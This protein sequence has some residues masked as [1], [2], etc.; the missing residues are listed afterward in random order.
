M[1]KIKIN[2]IKKNN[3]VTKKYIYKF[4][5]TLLV[6]VLFLI[7]VLIKLYS[8]NKHKNIQK[9]NV[10]NID[11][12]KCKIVKEK[13]LNRFKPFDFT[14]E[15]TFLAEL[16]SCDIPFSFSRFGDGEYSIMNGKKFYTTRDKWKWNHDNKNVQNSLIESSSICNYNNGFIGIPCKIWKE[17]AESIISFSNC[18]STKFMSYSTVFINK[19]FKNFKSWIIQYIYSS[20]RRKIILIANSLINKNISWAYK[21]FPVPNN[22]VEN[23]NNYIPSLLSKLS[24]IA[25]FNNLIFFISAGPAAN[26]I[27]SYLIKINNKNIYIDFGSAIEFITKGYSTR[28]YYKKSIENANYQCSSFII[29]N[30]TIIYE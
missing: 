24:E 7:L 19:N 8:K 6:I 21:F 17:I 12:Y 23:W 2:N 5:Y 28:N 16:I 26:I 4:D 20:N 29:K 10:V 18:S 14:K 15:F 9:E 11:I 27:I 1:K 30:G 22:L 25:K 3:K 13:L